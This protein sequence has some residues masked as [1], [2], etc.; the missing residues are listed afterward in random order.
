MEETFFL[1]CG[2]TFF[3]GT[4]ALIFFGFVAF[5]RYIRYRETMKL[6][7]KGLVHPRHSGIGN[8]KGTLRWG[9]VITGF[10]LAISAGLYPIGFVADVGFPLHFGPWMLAG[11]IPTFF[12]LSL[13]AIYMLTS[14][15]PEEIQPPS[16][17]APIAAA[18]ED[19][20]IYLDEDALDSDETED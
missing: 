13:L 12:G 20:A 15:K 5:I 9:L 3:F 18:D 4:L 10:G 2:S 1:I 19:D 6:A 16:A 8:G 17:P 14:Q 11:L 7:E